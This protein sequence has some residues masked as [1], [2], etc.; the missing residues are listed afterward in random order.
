VRLACFYAHD[1]RIM[2]NS[3]RY[4]VLA[5]VALLTVGCEIFQSQ[6][7]ETISFTMNG[8]AGEVVT[9]IYSKEF[10]AA[11]DEA[12][13][14]HLEVFGA[15][16]VVH[17]LPIDTIIDVRIERQLFLM[18]EPLASSDT[19]NVNVRIDVNDRSVFDGSGDLLPED[20]W[21]FLYRF[22]APPTQSVE[23]V[24]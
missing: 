7:P 14:T 3:I 12:G 9:I 24:I 23:V 8:T 13:V 5:A 2:K 19:V 15:D 10:V 1:S 11:T 20:P 18:A 6:A 17:T 22:N 21:Q 16:T 4:F